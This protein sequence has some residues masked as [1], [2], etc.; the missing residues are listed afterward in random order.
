MKERPRIFIATLTVVVLALIA[1][2]VVSGP[3]GRGVVVGLLGGLAVTVGIVI[4]FSRFVAKRVQTDLKAPPVPSGSWDYGMEATS[5]DG[6][7]VD[8][9]DF[10]GDVLVLN[11]WATWCGP[12][13]REMPS[14]AG[15]RERTADLGVRFACVTREKEADK[16]RAF[17]EKHG[18]TLPV[19]VLAGEPPEAFR[20]R[21]IPATFV[22]DRAGTIAMRHIGAA[23]WD[24]DSVV[25]FVRGLAAT[26][27]G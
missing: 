16:V 2:G 25:N 18:I 11:F 9:S 6:S 5:L 10:Q 3:F 4:F 12:C 27:G 26:P 17:A 20:T 21:G 24:A 15:L 8:F 14:L 23:R 7:P 19:Y 22:L 1:L 13:I